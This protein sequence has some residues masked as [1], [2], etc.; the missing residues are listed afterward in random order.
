MEYYV[1]LY[2]KYQHVPDP[3]LLEE[4]Q[5]TLCQSLGLKGR[6]RVSEEGINGTLG[7]SRK[8]LEAYTEV[9]SKVFPEVDWKFSRSDIDAFD[10]LRVRK[11]ESLVSRTAKVKYDAELCGVPLTPEEFHA[12]AQD[13]AAVLID[14]RNSYEFAIGHFEGAV[15]PDTRNFAR[16]SSWLSAERNGLLRGKTKFLMYCT[17]RAPHDQIE[18]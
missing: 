18:K 13:H 1:L 11:V 8:A 5:R 2:Y 14:V 9:C 16:F 10:N 3:N 15:N 4:S 6:V 7:G 12:H 17:V